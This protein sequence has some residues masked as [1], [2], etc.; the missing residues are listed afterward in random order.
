[1]AGIGKL[2]QTQRIG[3]MLV[4]ISKHGLYGCHAFFLFFIQCLRHSE[5][6]L[7]KQSGAFFGSAFGNRTRSIVLKLQ[8]Q[9]G[10]IQPFKQEGLINA[11]KLYERIHGGAGKVQPYF[12]PRLTAITAVKMIAPLRQKIGV[13]RYGCALPFV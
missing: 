11:V 9:I 7:H 1:M 8:Q 13:A 12:F 3:F 10:C 6:E 2:L 5:K 4:D